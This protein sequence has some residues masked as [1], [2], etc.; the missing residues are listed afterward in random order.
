LIVVTLLVKAVG[1]AYHVLQGSSRLDHAQKVNWV[2]RLADLEDPAASLEKYNQNKFHKAFGL[3]FHLDNLRMIAAAEPIDYP[4]PSET[5]HAVII[6]MYNEPY[7]V[8][9]PTIKSILNSSTDRDQMIIVLA[10]EGRAGK[11]T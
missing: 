8:L 9:E 3:D 2:E 5:Y 10:Y 1:I 11:T 6:A 7:D 4:R